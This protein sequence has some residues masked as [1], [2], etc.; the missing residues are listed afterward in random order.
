MSSGIVQKRA[1]DIQATLHTATEALDTVATTVGQPHQLK[2]TVGAFDQR[3]ARQ[4]VE[5]AEQFEIGPRGQLVIQSQILR[6]QPH[7]L[8]EL[9]GALMDEVPLERHRAAA[10]LNHTADHPQRCGF[11]RAVGPE[12]TD[13]FTDANLERHIID[14]DQVPETFLKMRDR[15]HR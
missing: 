8:F 4:A 5:S 12:Q 2:R 9:I 6:H 15:E 11:A 14:G 3:P 10:G 13:G 7:A 1:S